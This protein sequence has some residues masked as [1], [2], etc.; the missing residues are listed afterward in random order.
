M[1]ALGRS[2]TKKHTDLLMRGICPN[3]RCGEKLYTYQGI[4]AKECIICKSVFQRRWLGNR[5][6]GPQVW[7]RSC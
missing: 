5:K 6:R 4:E 3:P 2:L 7:I 1:I